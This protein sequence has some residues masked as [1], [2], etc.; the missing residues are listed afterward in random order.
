MLHRGRSQSSPQIFRIFGVKPD[1]DTLTPEFWFSRN[2]IEDQK[3]I[4]ELFES[5]NPENRL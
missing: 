5:P 4:Q 2:H 3:R 1:E